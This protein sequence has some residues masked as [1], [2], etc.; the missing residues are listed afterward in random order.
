MLNAA[1][2]GNAAEGEIISTWVKQYCNTYGKNIGITVSPKAESVMKSNS[3]T[4]IVF[5]CIGGAEGFLEARLTRDADKNCK[6][7]FIDDTDE[8]VIKGIR[9]HF[10]AFIIRP[11]EFKHIAQ[12]MKLCGVGDVR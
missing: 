12:A 1:V 10:S 4:D 11:I 5:I 7:V 3:K 6:I 9:L 8:Y 2:I